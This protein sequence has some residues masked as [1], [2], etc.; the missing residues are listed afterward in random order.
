VTKPEYKAILANSTKA[1]AHYFTKKAM[2]KLLQR[3]EE[4]ISEG[5]VV[6]PAAVTIPAGEV[7]KSVTDSL[8]A[9]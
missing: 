6:R 9:P 3:I 4:E 8:A 2:Q 5:A 1:V 7:E